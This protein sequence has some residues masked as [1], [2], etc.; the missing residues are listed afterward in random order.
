MRHENVSILKGC[1]RK[2]V[3]LMY[4]YYLK[5]AWKGLKKYYTPFLG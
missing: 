3:G 1:G 4:G 2:Q 5:F